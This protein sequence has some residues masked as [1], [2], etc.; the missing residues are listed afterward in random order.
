[1]GARPATWA[2]Q[3][4][5][6]PGNLGA[7]AWALARNLGAAVWAL[8]RQLGSETRQ[9]GREARQFGRSPATTIG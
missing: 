8:A 9:F 2:R 1:L 6:S 5:R 4:G 7:A 3:L